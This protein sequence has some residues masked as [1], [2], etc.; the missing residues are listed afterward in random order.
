MKKLI[1]FKPFSESE[2]DVF[3]KQTIAVDN[4]Y[5]SELHGEAGA[6]YISWYSDDDMV[7]VRWPDGAIKYYRLETLLQG[8][9]ATPLSQVEDGKLL[10]FVR[11]MIYTEDYNRTAIADEYKVESEEVFLPR[12]FKFTFTDG[13]YTSKYSIDIDGNI[14]LTM[15]PRTIVGTSD[16]IFAKKELGRRMSLFW[17]KLITQVAED[18]Y[19]VTGERF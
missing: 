18:Y 6:Y 17:T 3:Q 16:E 11:H 8:D 14:I 5:R 9:D 12:V 4:T 7:S 1:R 15:P 10:S 2:S 13:D 19:K